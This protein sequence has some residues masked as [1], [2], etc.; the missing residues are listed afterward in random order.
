MIPDSHQP[1]GTLV[2]SP[3][4]DDAAFSIGGLLHEG[5]FAPVTIVTV[6]GR[7]NFLG[8]RGFQRDAEEATSIRRAEDAAFAA[9]IGADLISCELPDASIRLGPSLESIFGGDEAAPVELRGMLSEIV[10]RVRP[11]LIL[12]PAAIG[13][14]VDHRILHT[15][16]PQLARSCGAA[17]AYYEDL[18]YA[19]WISVEGI[20]LHFAR[21]SAD[22]RPFDVV[23]GG[24]LVTKL[25]SIMLYRTQAMETWV[26]SIRRHA[27]RRH[28]EGAE[29]IWATE[30]AGSW[31]RSILHDR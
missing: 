12:A 23:P 31:L 5:A 4:P 18:P 30:E 26:A 16:A 6:F 27:L 10:H 11:A 25:R 20:S 1:R 8:A 17:L 9:A 22:L 3:H 2:L 13:G 15:V 14:H 24:A 28:P 7:T 29:R 19:E 21:I